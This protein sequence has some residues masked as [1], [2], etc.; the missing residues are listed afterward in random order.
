[1]ENAYLA[2]TLPTGRAPDAD[3]IA[4]MNSNW[5][6]TGITKTSSSGIVGMFGYEIGDNDDCPWGEDNGVC[7]DEYYFYMKFWPIVDIF[8][9]QD[10]IFRV[11]FQVGGDLSDWAG[12]Y[13]KN[14]TPDMTVDT[15]FVPVSIASKDITARL[16]WDNNSN[17]RG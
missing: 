8:N 14:E 15:D 6:A 2:A 1:M 5:S 16:N 13:Y 3:H 12:V 4:D 17:F 9:T 7:D 11:I 10:A